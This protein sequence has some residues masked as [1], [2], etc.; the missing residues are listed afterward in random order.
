MIR[1][2]IVGCGR[3]LAAHL[4]GYRILR[5]AGVDDFQITALCARKEAD[6]RSYIQRGEGPA[7]RKAVST[8][9]GDP[10]AIDDEYLS[11]FQPGVKVEVFEDYREMIKNGS[12]DAV[13]DFTIHSLHHQVADVS[14]ANGKHL[15]SQKPLAVTVRAARQMCERAEAAGVT[16]GVFENLRYMLGIRRTK[17]A[18][19]PEGPLGD[20]QMALFGCAGAWWAPDQIVAET[21]W[22]HRLQEAGG[23]ALDM[24]PHWFDMVRYVGGEVKSVSAQTSVIEP[25]R[26]TRDLSGAVLEQINCD[27]DDT[28]FANFETHAGARGTIYGSWAGH[29]GPT[30]AGEGAVFYGSRGRLTGD[31]M[32]LDDGKMQSLESAHHPETPL[33]LT[34]D[35]ALA[36]YDWLEAI[37]QGGNPE[38]SGEEGL[39]DLACAFAVVESD[40]AKCQVKVAE[41]EN[42]TIDSYQ[43]P[44]NRHFGIR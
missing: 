20:L 24:G 31:A 1:I 28:F 33:G 29:G 23:I 41:V 15:M 14:F 5:E 35:F 9:E 36:Q 7:Q 17:W 2:G 30:M 11:D 10:L 22:R 37:R 25:I 27:A 34:D 12:I 6:A 16:F 43:E 19:G 13:N 42:G 39:K 18:F 32:S 38:T 40:K 3:I 8:M 44:L 26:Y 21:A 4:R